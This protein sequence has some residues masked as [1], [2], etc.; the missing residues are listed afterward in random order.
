MAQA[1]PTHHENLMTAREVAL[2]LGVSPDTV[3]RWAQR[4][5]IPQVRPNGEGKKPL[6]FDVRDVM[7]WRDSKK[8]QA[9]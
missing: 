3:R 1:I 6:L 4:R 9:E 5:E 8:V 7:R 2:L